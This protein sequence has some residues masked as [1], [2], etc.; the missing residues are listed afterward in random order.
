MLVNASV[1]YLEPD[2]DEALNEAILYEPESI[3]C[4]LPCA[5]HPQKAVLFSPLPGQVR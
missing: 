3:K 4:S 1:E 5:P 2:E